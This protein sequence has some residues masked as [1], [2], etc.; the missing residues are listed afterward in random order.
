MLNVLQ[1]AI[2]FKRIIKNYYR[3]IFLSI[4]NQL[5]NFYYF[6]LLLCTEVGFDEIKKY[7]SVH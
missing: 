7:I 2:L 4:I 6:I 3:L 5:F 1:L